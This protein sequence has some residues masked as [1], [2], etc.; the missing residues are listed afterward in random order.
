MKKK[1]RIGILLDSCI[2]PA[3]CFKMLEEINSNPGSEIILI[4]K[5]IPEKK[6]EISLLSRMLAKR[7]SFLYY[8]F[9]KIENKLVKLIPDAFELKDISSILSANT[10]KTLEVNPIRTKFS[11]K[12]SEIDLKEIEKYN[13]DIFIRMGFRILRGDILKTAKYGVWSYHHGDNK[14][15]RG[16]PAGFWEVFQNKPETGVVLQ[17]LSEAV[18]DGKI[19]LKS[20][21]STHKSSPIRNRNNYY[22]KACSFLPQKIQELYDLGED[23]FFKKVEELNRYP[24]FY[25]KRLYR[26]PSNRE[27]V[28]LSS[29]LFLKILKNRIVDFFYFY[30]W[31]LLFRLSSSNSISKIFFQFK[32]II[33]PKDRFWADPHILRRNDKYYIFIEELIY[34]SN[35]GHIS[36]IVMDDTGSYT[37]PVKVLERDYHLS[38][39]FLIE[40]HGELYMIP[41]TSQHRTIELYKCTLFPLEWE[42]EKILMSN[43]CAVDSTI[44]FKENKYWLFANIARNIGASNS[45]EL[46]LFSSNHLISNNWVPHPDNPIISNVSQARPAG[47]FFTY[48]ENLYRPSQNGSRRYGHGMRINQVKELNE[49][50]YREEIVDSI[51]PDWDRSLRSTHTINSVGKLTVIDAEMKR[52]KFI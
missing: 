21:S 34:S 5:S 32:K 36:L 27:M 43:I 3:W 51:F 11:D 52:R 26:I 2:L 7:D 20:F 35:K 39:P 15:N 6:K 44:L 49:T 33:P 8:L 24:Q 13:I 25:S 37:E 50:N 17:I 14:V 19:L 48:K 40:D 31:V 9:N 42:L 46:F 28:L 47:N 23:L 45:D 10:I 18:D 29:R 12:I 1:L 38:Y 41:E 4:V 16:G 30:Q 22:W